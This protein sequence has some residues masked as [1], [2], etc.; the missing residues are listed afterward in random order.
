LKKMVEEGYDSLMTVSSHTPFFWKV[1]DGKS[2]PDYDPNNRP[3]RQDILDEE[4][5]YHDN[6][7]IYITEADN[8]RVNGRIGSNPLLYET[9]TFES[10][11]IDTEEDFRLMEGLAKQRGSLL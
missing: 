8:L 10:M 5:M 9:T 3:R 2:I 6:G 7:N 4:I 11:Q 1:K